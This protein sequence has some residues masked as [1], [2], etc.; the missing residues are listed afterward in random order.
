MGG[1]WVVPL[2]GARCL[3]LR[4]SDAHAWSEVTYINREQDLGLEGL[5]RAKQSY[6]P[7]RM[8]DKFRLTPLDRPEA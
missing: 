4:Q 3:E 5:R 1:R 6:R 8:V 7:V 2:G